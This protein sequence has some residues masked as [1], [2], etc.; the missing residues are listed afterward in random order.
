LRNKRERF[1]FDVNGGLLAFP[2]FFIVQL[3]KNTRNSSL[4][5]PLRMSTVKFIPVPAG[6]DVHKGVY[7]RCLFCRT[8]ICTEVFV[9]PNGKNAGASGTIVGKKHWF[10]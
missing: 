4:L 8:Y 5:S 10:C 2:L 1:A 7:C 3:K 9:L 6:T